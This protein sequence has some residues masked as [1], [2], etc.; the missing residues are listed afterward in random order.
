MGRVLNLSWGREADYDRILKC[1]AGGRATG[2]FD[3]LVRVAALRDS[4]CKRSSSSGHSPGYVMQ[5]GDARNFQA[6]C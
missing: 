1:I 2:I 3:L 5:P 4:S 6:P